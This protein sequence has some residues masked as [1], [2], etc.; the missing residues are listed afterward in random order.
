LKKEVSS[1]HKNNPNYRRWKKRNDEKNYKSKL[2]RNKRHKHVNRN[3]LKKLQSV[4]DAI[5]FKT[6]IVP[7]IFSIIDNPEETINFFNK[8]ITQVENIRINENK[9][10]S[11]NFLINMENTTHITCDALM[12]LLTIIR[13]TRGVKLLPINWRGNF[14]KDKEMN[15][16]LK[17]SGFLKYMET[18][19]ENLIRTSRNIQIETG[20]G[21]VYTDGIDIRKKVI[22]FTCKKVNKSNIEINFLFTMLTE[23]ITN[24]SDHA[25]DKENLFEH[26]WYIFVENDADKIKYTFMDNGLGIPTTIKKK[27]FEEFLESFNL[28]KE[29]KYIEA[30]VSGIEKRSK[31]GQIE[32]GNGLPSIYEQFTSNKISNLVI[33][34]NRAYYLKDYSRDLENDLKGTIFCWEIKKEDVIDGN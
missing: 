20:K 11:R 10:F 33:I 2:K 4:K 34:S 17:N 25:Y 5:P 14:P 18:A 1:I 7:S 3:E 9:S 15:Q 22:D 23:M 16:F 30:G 12:Y 26:S 24:I 28:D 31:T 27:R 19:K 21:Y 32:R 6:F 8:I 13:N 29:Y